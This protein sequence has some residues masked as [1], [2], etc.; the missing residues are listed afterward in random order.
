MIIRVTWL[1][2]ALLAFSNP[3][4]GEG[5]NQTLKRARDLESAGRLKA[6]LDLYRM[7]YQKHPGRVDI[8]YRLEGLLSKTGQ[9]QEAITLLSRHLSRNPQNITAHFRLGDALFEEG[10]QEAAFQHWDRVL[11]GARHEGPFA[12]A[13]DR[14]GRHNLHQKALE[15]YLLGRKTLNNPRLFPREI[16]E[17][18]ERLA[19]YPDAIS[20]YLIFLDQKPQYLAL[21]ESRLRGIAREGDKTE[22]VYA[23]LESEVAGDPGENKR[24][25]LFTEFAIGSGRVGPALKVLLDQRI[26]TPSQKSRLF[27]I[28]SFALESGEYEVSREAYRAILSSPKKSNLTPRALLG[29]A[30]AHQG[31]GENDQSRY[32]YVDLAERYPGR[33]EVDEARFHLATLQLGAYQ[34]TDAA[35]ATL[36]ALLDSKRKSVWRY[37]ALFH[38]A[39]IRIRQDQMHLAKTAFLQVIEE[40]TGHE[41]AD[42]AK[43]ELAES[44]FYTH[45]FDSAAVLLDAI[46]EGT[47]SG[48]ALNDAM[49]LSLLLEKG[50]KEGEEVLLHFADASRLMRQTRTQDALATLE[51]FLKKHPGSALKDRALAARIELLEKMERYTETIQACRRFSLDLPESPLCAWSLMTLGRIHQERLGQYHDALRTF[52]TLLFKYPGSLEADL[53]RDRVRI[54]QKRIEQIKETG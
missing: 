17:L 50:N 4:A 33:A 23:R 47:P 38:L 46:L 19:R 29:M 25:R 10:K 12:L 7:L 9:R 16:A 42:Q 5:L 34:D 39:Q 49:D 22:Q 20:E 30:R 54:L 51:A 27:R 1:L 26:Q 11:E 48:Y 24:L 8:L 45:R 3:A 6:S 14:Y 53:A 13:A 35:I 44:H 37:K 31:L 40:Q 36:E 28:A 32:L 52:E 18:Y 21:V 41:N 2:V 15:I 43:F